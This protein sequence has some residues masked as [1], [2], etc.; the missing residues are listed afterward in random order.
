ME[1]LPAQLEVRNHLMKAQKKQRIQE[2]QRIQG[3]LNLS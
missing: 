2:K 3:K 1:I